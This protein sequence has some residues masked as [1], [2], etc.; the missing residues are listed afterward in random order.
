M[1]P[2]GLVPKGLGGLPVGSEEQARGLPTRSPLLF[3][4]RHLVAVASVAKL[5]EL[6]ASAT[7]RDPPGRDSL[8]DLSQ[9]GFEMLQADF[10]GEPLCLAGIPTY[11]TLTA[12]NRYCQPRANRPTDPP[13]PVPRIQ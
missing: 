6:A 4:E 2:D 7:H 3:G 1:H 10:L 8:L 9:P 12:A 5:G 11:P 13:Q